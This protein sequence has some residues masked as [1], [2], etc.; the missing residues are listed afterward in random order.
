[1]GDIDYFKCNSEIY[2]LNDIVNN[3]KKL[4]KYDHLIIVQDNPNRTTAII[5]L[6]KSKKNYSKK[7]FT[8]HLPKSKRVNLKNKLD[9]IECSICKETFFKNEFFRELPEC[10]H[11]FHKK[12]ID[13][14]FYKSQSYNC[15]YCR[16]NFY[17]I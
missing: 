4:K 5:R 15:P 8:F 16:N 14:W 1:M 17:K 2:N 9:D 7:D 6:D 11:I 13:Q 3:F 12:C 10:K